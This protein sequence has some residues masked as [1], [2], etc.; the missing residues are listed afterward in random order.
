MVMLDITTGL[1]EHVGNCTIGGE[2]FS[3]LFSIVT[4]Y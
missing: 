3:S 4:E 1:Y 2:Q